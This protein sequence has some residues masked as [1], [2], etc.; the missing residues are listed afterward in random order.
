MAN[1]DDRSDNVRKL[2]RNIQNTMRNMREAE[3]YLE[4]HAD[5]MRPEDVA[6]VEAKNERRAQAIAGFRREIQD[7]VHRFD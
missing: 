1:P 2:Q 6:A 3:D 4:A 5:E 7:E